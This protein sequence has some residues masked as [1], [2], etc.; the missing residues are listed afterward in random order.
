MRRNAPKIGPCHAR[1]RLQ[2]HVGYCPESGGG[3]AVVCGAKSY[4]CEIA[5]VAQ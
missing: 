3:L 4:G 2:G 1:A 5:K